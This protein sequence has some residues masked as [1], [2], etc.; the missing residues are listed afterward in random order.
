MA[1][2]NKKRAQPREERVLS[3]EVLFTGKVFGVRRDRVI[4]PNGVEATREVVTHPGSV[5]VLP[6]FGDE[7]ILLI[8]QYRHA[9]GQYLWELVA[10]RRDQGEKFH[11]AAIREL[12]EETGYTAKTMRELMDVFPTPGFVSER[13]VIFLAE[14]LTKG[15]ANPEPDEKIWMRPFRLHK[16]LNWIRK[17]KIRDAKSIAGILY[18]ATFVHSEHR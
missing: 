4:E 16:A 1:T 17:G 13:M 10:G 11:R 18:Y 14:G 7:R 15:P 6:V 9:A 12:A 8:R 5:V 2:K 3:S